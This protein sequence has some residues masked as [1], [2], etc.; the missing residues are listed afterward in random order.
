MQQ[1]YDCP[2]CRQLVQFGQSNCLSCGT[3][4]NWPAQQQSQPSPRYQRQSGVWDQQQGNSIRFDWMK[5]KAHLLLLSKFLRGQEISYFLKLS[6]FLQDEKINSFFKLTDWQDVLGESPQKA[7]NRFIDEGMLENADLRTLLLYKYKVT[8]LKNLLK[9]RKSVVKGN[10][11]ELVQ[12]L[13][14]IDREGMNKL[15]LGTDLLKCTQAG[16]VIVEQYVV[17][18]KSKR[19]NVE[20]QVMEYLANHQFREACIAVANYEAEQIFP[21]GM[22]IDWKKYDPTGQIK[23]LNFI[24]NDKPQM[25]SKIED[26]KLE[27]LRIAAA[28]MGLWGVI[29]AKK[30]LPDSFEIGIQM[31]NE[32]AARLL[33]FHASM[34]EQLEVYASTGTKYVEILNTTSDSCESCKKLQGKLFKINQAP[35]LPNPQCSYDIGCRCCYSPVWNR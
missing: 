29:T 15:S 5:S 18:E 12:R 3:Q 2:Q 30:W 27:P 6:K 35:E 24:F 4:L 21:R 14:M 7:I 1:W 10:K 19:I 11:D 28:M 9:Q 20:Q 25:L 16:S 34:K 8:E 31:D 13:I 23:L 22:G 32:R 17:S 33:F 26:T